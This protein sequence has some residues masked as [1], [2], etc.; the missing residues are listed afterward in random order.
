VKKLNV[1]P[2]PR[3]HRSQMH[4]V[5][6]DDLFGDNEVSYDMVKKE[7]CSHLCLIIEGWHSLGPLHKIIDGHNDVFVA[8]VGCRVACHEVNP[9]FV[10]WSDNDNR[11]Q[12]R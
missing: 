1:K 10:K 8:I 4:R 2:T 6:R 3:V 11:M 12:G 9:S 5:V 7:M